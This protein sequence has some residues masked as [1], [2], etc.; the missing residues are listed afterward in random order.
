ML[1]SCVECGAW[2]DFT[3]PDDDAKNTALDLARTKDP[4][5]IKALE[6]QVEYLEN[7]AKQ[8]EEE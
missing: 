2:M 8:A 1:K 5:I 4:K 7:L 3:M 6:A